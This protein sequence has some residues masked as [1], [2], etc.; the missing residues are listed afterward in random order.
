MAL[1]DGGEV[2]HLAGERA[3]ALFDVDAMKVAWAGSRHAVEVNDRMARL[4]ASDP[5]SSPIRFHSIRFQFPLT[6][7]GPWISLLLRPISSILPKIKI[8]LLRNHHFTS[9][10]TRVRSIHS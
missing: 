5:V 2:D 9:P 4:V 10:G 1:L 8:G 7:H 3:T 6:H